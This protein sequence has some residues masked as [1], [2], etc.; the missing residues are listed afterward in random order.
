[1]PS[2]FFIVLRRF[3]FEKIMTQ[4]CNDVIDYV[5]GSVNRNAYDRGYRRAPSFARK[6]EQLREQE[7]QHDEELNN[8]RLSIVVSLVTNR[9]G[10]LVCGAKQKF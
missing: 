10:F 9:R 8:A 2:D 4:F 3:L 6:M 1:M 7:F 5:T